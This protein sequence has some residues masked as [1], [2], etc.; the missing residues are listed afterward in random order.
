MRDSSRSLDGVWAL[1]S[2]RACAWR[3]ARVR[4]ERRT[5]KLELGG[6]RYQPVLVDFGT[7]S[8]VLGVAM[9]A[10]DVPAWARLDPQIPWVGREESHSAGEKARGPGF[11]AWPQTAAPR[12]GRR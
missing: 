4:A 5:L 3:A 1:M 2:A 8:G 11:E 10:L 12:R 9:C 6:C 7:H